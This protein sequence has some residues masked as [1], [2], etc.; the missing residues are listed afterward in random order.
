MAIRIWETLDGEASS[1]SELVAVIT[2]EFDVDPST[3]RAD[4]Q[5]FLAGAMQREM[6][7][8]GEPMD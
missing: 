5:E 6:I 2:R 7:E 3:A 4:I 1:V 8:A